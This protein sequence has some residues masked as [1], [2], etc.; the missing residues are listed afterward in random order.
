MQ[1]HIIT[2]PSFITLSR[3]AKDI[4]GQ[5]FGRL[6]ALGPVAIDKWVKWLCQCDCG[7][8]AVVSGHDLRRAKTESRSCE[9]SC[10][11][12]SREIF[13]QK[14]RTHGMTGKR[15]YRIWRGV[16]G[17]CTNPN[18]HNYADYGGRGITIYVEWRKSFEAFQEY[19]SKLPHYDEE[20]YTLDRIDNNGN[21]EPGNVRWA[22]RSEQNR[23]KRD[24]RLLTFNGKT[25]C[26]ASWATELGVN[27]DILYRRLRRGWDAVAV[28]SGPF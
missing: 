21:Y 6:V 25:Q 15:I 22:T 18:I 8:T 3:N 19:V 14:L 27:A 17:R 24:T 10:G 7:N 13:A 12:L 2:R 28:L 23:N 9:K 26:V 4:T 5:R 11:C 16:I 1:P 20:D